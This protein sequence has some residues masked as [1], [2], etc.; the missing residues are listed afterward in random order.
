M[1]LLSW[2]V[3]I[4]EMDGIVMRLIIELIV[5]KLLLLCMVLRVIIMNGQD[6]RQK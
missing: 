6:C 5:V 4:W 1:L 3:L 2:N